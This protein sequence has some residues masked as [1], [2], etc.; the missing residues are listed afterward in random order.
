MVLLGQEFNVNKEMLINLVIGRNLYN[1]KLDFIREYLQ[2]SMDALKMKFWMDLEDTL[3]P[4]TS[5][6]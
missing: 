1:S 4:T 2:N 3:F 5:N 6:I